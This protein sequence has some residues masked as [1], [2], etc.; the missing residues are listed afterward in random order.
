MASINTRRNPIAYDIGYVIDDDPISCTVNKEILQRFTGR[1]EIRVFQNPLEAQKDLLRLI[2]EPLNIIIFLDIEMPQL[3]G[4]D[5]LSSLYEPIEHHPALV[6]VVF[7]SSALQHFK[8]HPMINCDLV[9]GKL[10]KLNTPKEF[11]RVFK[12]NSEV[13]KKGQ[14]AANSA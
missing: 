14:P 3:T 4:P 9:I 12:N 6:H 1:M 2:K 7:I 8:N 10:G 13:T 5:L 11:R